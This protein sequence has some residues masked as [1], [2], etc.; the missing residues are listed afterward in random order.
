MATRSGSHRAVW[1]AVAAV[2][3]A[4]AVF[5]PLRIAYKQHQTVAAKPNGVAIVNFAFTPQTLT[6]RAG[7]TVTFTNTDGAV[8]TATASDKSF[9]SGRL[10]QGG[11]FKARIT[12][13]VTYYCSIHQ[14][15]NAE[16]KV[17]S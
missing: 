13:P 2:M 17:A 12:K 7:T 10:E 6:V 5:V 16:I 11:S 1:L 9:D 14:Y 3:G 4:T 8:H 15:M